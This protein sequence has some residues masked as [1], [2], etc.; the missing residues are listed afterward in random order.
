MDDIVTK[1][2]RYRES[3]W[4]LHRRLPEYITLGKNEIKELEDYF[5][6]Y[7]TVKPKKEGKTKENI[8]SVAGMKLIRSDM[9]SIIFCS[10]VA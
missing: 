4:R 10:V 6:G 2:F 8:E 7:F 1:I 9:D 3:Y 5:D